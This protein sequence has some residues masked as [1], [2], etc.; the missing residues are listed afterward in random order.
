[1]EGSCSAGAVGPPDGLRH[2]RAAAKPGEHEQ[3]QRIRHHLD[4]VGAH[5]QIDTLQ[6][7]LDRGGRAEHEAGGERAERR[8]AADDDGGESQEAAPAGH[9][10]GEGADVLQHEDRAA[11]T[12]DRT[13]GD[14]GNPADTNGIIAGGIDRLR[15]LAART[16]CQARP[17]AME[18]EM[19]QHDNRDR[20]V[21][22]RRLP[23]KSGPKHGQI[24]QVGKRDGAENVETDHRCMAAEQP[25]DQEAGETER[26]DA[27]GEPRH[28]LVGAE[29]RHRDRDDTGDRGT[30]ENRTPNTDENTAAGEGADRCSEC[31]GEHH[32]FDP[33]REDA[34]TFGQQTTE[35]PE[36]E[37]HRD[38][39]GCGE[40]I[41]DEKGVHDAD[42]P[43]KPAGAGC[44]G[45]WRTARRQCSI[46]GSRRPATRA[47][48]RPAAWRAPRPAES[49]RT[50]RPE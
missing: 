33:D 48:R 49:R 14:N 16:Q 32:A 20:R 22:Q 47:C 36:D 19:H 30:A 26:Q 18:K 11:E 17:G 25:A 50:V 40:E 23:E 5:R 28:H 41:G 24:R 13:A 38:A 9:A 6:A 4:D 10:V 8:P 46:P 43:L 31:A 21:G 1:M 15:V 45:P 29:P 12:G 35:R 44:R 7:H 39:H 27:D 34:S 42:L 3:R 37:R 2:A